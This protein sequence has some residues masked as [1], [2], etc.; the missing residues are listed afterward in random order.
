MRYPSLEYR[1]PEQVEAAFADRYGVSVQW[2]P[3]HRGVLCAVF[4]FFKMVSSFG[5][6]DS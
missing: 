4:R 3:G 5:P 2:R 1:T 6:F